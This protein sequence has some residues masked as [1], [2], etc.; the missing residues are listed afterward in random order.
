MVF[1]NLE[2]I[3]KNKGIKKV[4]NLP[5]MGKQEVYTQFTDEELNEL[6]NHPRSIIVREVHKQMTPI[7][8][9]ISESMPKEYSEVKSLFEVSNRNDEEEDM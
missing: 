5:I 7:F 2:L 8:E 9:L 3:I 4:L 6:I 1:D